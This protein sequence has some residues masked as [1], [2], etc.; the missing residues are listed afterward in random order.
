MRH[1][2]ARRLSSADRGYFCLRAAEEDEAAGTAS[3]CEARLVHAELARAYRQRCAVR[4][5]NGRD[6]HETD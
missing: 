6:G 1:H 2:A 4:L 3:C 5:E